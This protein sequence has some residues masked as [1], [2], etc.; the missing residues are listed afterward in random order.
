MRIVLVSDD[1]LQKIE[2]AKAQFGAE[3]EEARAD[4]LLMGFDREDAAEMSSD[5][6]DVKAC[7]EVLP[8]TLPDI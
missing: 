3:Y 6:V 7:Y 1:L 4:V 2:E 8:I 5:W